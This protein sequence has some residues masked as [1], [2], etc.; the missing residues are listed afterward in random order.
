MTRS[1]EELIR[2]DHFIKVEK[3]D[4]NQHHDVIIS[5]KQKNFDGLRAKLID[6]SSLKS[7]NYGKYLSREEISH[8]TDCSELSDS[9]QKY[10]KGLNFQ[11]ISKSLH[12]EYITVRGK[13]FDW[14]N[15]LKTKFYNYKHKASET[16]FSRAEEYSV[17]EE[18]RH[19]IYTFLNVEEFPPIIERNTANT[20][21]KEISIARKNDFFAYSIQ[22]DDLFGYTTPTKIKTFYG[23]NDEEEI[24]DSSKRNNTTQCVFQS[25]SEFFSPLDLRQFETFFHLPK[26]L[27]DKSIGGHEADTMCHKN[28]FYCYE[29][30]LIIQYLSS[31]SPHTSTKF[32]YLEQDVFSSW[33]VAAASDENPP[34]VQILAFS[35]YEISMS[36]LYI[37]L[38]NME[39]VKLALQGVTLITS[40]GDDGA[41]GFLARYSNIFCGYYPHFPASSPFVTTVGGTQGI[42]KGMDEVACQS[43][44]GG[45]ITSGG[46]FSNFYETPIWQKDAITEYI[47]SFI[48]ATNNIYQDPLS[49]H[50]KFLNVTGRGYPDISLA[51][52]KYITFSGEK[53]LY[54]S[55]TSASAA[56]FGSMISLI[57]RDR[58]GRGM[59]T[60]GYIN[61]LLYTSGRLFTKDIIIGENKCTADACC[62]EGYHAGVGW[63][64]VTGLGSIDF[65][66][67]MH[68][69]TTTNTLNYTQSNNSSSSTTTTTIDSN[70]HLIDIFPF[71]SFTSS[72]SSFRYT[73]STDHLLWTTVI[74]STIASILLLIILF[75]RRW[76]FDGMFKRRRDYQRIANLPP[77]RNATTTSNRPTAVDTTSRLSSDTVGIASCPSIN[78]PDASLFYPSLK[79]MTKIDIMVVNNNGNSF[80]DP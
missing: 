74:L 53:M 39:A 20:L 56:V 31:G 51:A 6:I 68:Y 18:I 48:P 41:S 55:S 22:N 21:E 19:L 23:M 64:P 67:L 5:V 54:V 58:I 66:G 28:P 17:P 78:T 63:D 10:F 75:R 14:E 62:A 29:S 59:P 72:T 46:G 71:K 8:Y 34:K 30:N 43:D 76:I 40:S 37:N 25:Y 12:G 32:W 16:Y 70:K 33:I 3:S 44:K 47:S 69:L 79:N 35:A 50:Y 4:A 9:V 52:S 65:P 60:V 2:N 45:G 24:L 49:S 7:P 26:S 15:I 11:I 13:I 77:L 80:N 36:N 27:L 57:N 42:E 73:K 1:I 61:P 38:F